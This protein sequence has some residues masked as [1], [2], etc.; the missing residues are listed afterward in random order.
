MYIYI[1]IYILLGLIEGCFA[2]FEV[3]RCRQQKG[4]AKMGSDS[5]AWRPHAR[6]GREEPNTQVCMMIMI[7]GSR[8]W[9]HGH[10]QPSKCACCSIGSLHV[11]LFGCMALWLYVMCCLLFV[12][13]E[14]RLYMLLLVLLLKCFVVYVC[15]LYVLLR[16]ACTCA[17]S[18][19]TPP[20]IY[21]YI[22]I[23]DT[24][25]IVYYLYIMI[26]L[27]ICIY[28]YIYIYIRHL[29]AGAIIIIIN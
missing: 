22:Y 20:Y 24:Y 3:N 21:I 8:E 16:V 17:A 18:G 26:S 13:F 14:G 5:S 10:F 27:Y 1:Y 29:L 6:G 25:I 19:T 2:P 9:S 28:T 4:K 11:L 12:L 23:C 15:L 7:A